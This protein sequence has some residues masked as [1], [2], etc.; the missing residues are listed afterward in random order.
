[1][2]FTANLQEMEKSLFNYF[3]KFSVAEWIE[4]RLNKKL[5]ILASI[6]SW[7][8]WPLGLEDGSKENQQEN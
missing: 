7:H 1:M 4:H 5:E 2:V 3:H 6:S 8:Q